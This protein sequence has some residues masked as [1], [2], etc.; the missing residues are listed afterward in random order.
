MGE[1]ETLADQGRYE[2]VIGQFP[3]LKTYNHGLFLFATADDNSRKNIIEALENATAKVIAEI[4]WL[5]K[6]V[7]C[8]GKAPGNSGK[9]T[10][11][12]WPSD[13]PL[14]SLVRVKDCSDICPA[15]ADLIK[16]QAPISSF[17]GSIL[18]PFPGFPLSYSE[19]E[20]GPAP[21][22]AI[23][24]NFVKGGLLLNFSNQH[25]MM[26]ATGLFTFIMLL[27]STMRGESIP[28]RI[29][30]Q[31]NRDP[32]TVVPLLDEGEVIKDHSHLVRP[33]ASTPVPQTALSTA[34][35]PR[36]QW[37]YFRFLK[38]SITKVKAL[39]TTAEGTND[40]AV[41]FISSND[42]LCAFYWKRLAAVRL[43]H[44]HNASTKS[45]FSR[46]I[47]ART[48]MKVPMGYMGQLVYQA[49][50]Y[51]SHEELTSMSL[52]AVTARLRGAL[53]E[54]N[55]PFAI[56]SYATFLASVEDKATLAYAGIFNPATDIGSSSMSTAQVNLSFGILGEPELCRRPRLAP[57]PGC[58]Y[59]YPPEAKGDL[60]VLVCLREEELVG[61]RED[62]EWSECT[63]YI[64]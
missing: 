12:P 53:N 41:P 46:A 22:V 42:A 57:V 36:Y 23:Q 54:A 48:A 61:L 32:K 37:A 1:P 24:A 60:P 52:Q 9:Y 35:P 39:A 47:D 16:A 2:D 51:M 17:D 29:I 25:N 13:T 56:R 28:P 15:Y 19:A 7:V 10:L 31:A 30:E 14:S 50:T 59:F 49:A 44:G 34:A 38:P 58:L 3:Q 63:E 11:A 6:Q 20:I 55:T 64:G 21:V 62:R 8:E 43:Q 40:K 33:V 26:D 27:A 4:P 45:K 18:C 5:A